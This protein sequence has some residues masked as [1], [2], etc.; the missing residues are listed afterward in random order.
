[1]FSLKQIGSHVDYFV[2]TDCT[3]GGHG[4]HLKYS[5]CLQSSQS[6]CVY[7]SGMYTFM[8]PRRT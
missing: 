3:W 5:Q 6:E 4:D 8:L 2:V 7:I 1:M